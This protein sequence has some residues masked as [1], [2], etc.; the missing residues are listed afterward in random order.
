M[1]SSRESVRDGTKLAA[2]DDGSREPVVDCVRPRWRCISN[3]ASNRPW[4]PTSP[5]GPARVLYPKPGYKQ[6]RGPTPAGGPGVPACPFFRYFADKR[7]ALFAASAELEE[8]SRAAW[9]GAPATASPLDLV[10]TVLDTMAGII[11]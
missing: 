4:W 1:T 3:T 9:G 11:G 5:S 2:W 8:K 10:A 6:P 7:E